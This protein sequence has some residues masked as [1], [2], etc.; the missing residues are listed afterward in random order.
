MRKLQINPVGAEEVFEI[1]LDPTKHPVAYNNKLT[2]LVDAGM[3]YVQA[4]NFIR[5]T[6]F[7]MEVYYA[8]NQGL[9]LVE[10]EAIESVDIHNPYDGKTIPNPENQPSWTP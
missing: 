1:Y 2:E 6:P 7:V 3:S 5:N 4:E 9:F 10:S 8:P